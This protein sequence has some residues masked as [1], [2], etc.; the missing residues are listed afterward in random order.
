[1]ETSR[2]LLK[3][4]PPSSEMAPAPSLVEFL[5]LPNYSV[6]PACLTL[7]GIT[8]LPPRAPRSP[9]ST[10]AHFLC[11][12]P[13]PS[14]AAPPPRPAGAP[15]PPPFPQIL[16]QISAISW[17]LPTPMAV[18]LPAALTSSLDCLSSLVP[19]SPPSS[20]L[21]GELCPTHSPKVVRRNPEC[22]RIWREGL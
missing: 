12:P 11:H 2:R 6:S 15:R 4:G 1:M 21:V 5:P 13:T 18:G 19:L 16:L 10:S 20:G 8:L 17:F 9:H 14:S 7:G 3:H 22:D